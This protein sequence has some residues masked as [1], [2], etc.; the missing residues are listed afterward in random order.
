M[1][2]APFQVDAN[3]QIRDAE[4]SVPWQRMTDRMKLLAALETR[5]IERAAAASAA[6]EH[7]KVLAEDARAC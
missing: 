2:Y 4:M 1:A 7:A 3:G 5:F 6:E